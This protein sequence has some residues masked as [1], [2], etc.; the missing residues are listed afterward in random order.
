MPL[1]A[2]SLDETWQSARDQ[3][4]Y[5]ELISYSSWDIFSNDLDPWDMRYEH[6]LRNIRSSTLALS[7]VFGFSNFH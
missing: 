7:L 3:S 2:V 5:R 1:R 6:G 4:N